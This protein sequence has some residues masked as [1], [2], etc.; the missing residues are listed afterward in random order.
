[1]RNSS[2]WLESYLKYAAVTEAPREMHF[3]TGVSVLA[4][5]LRRKVWLDMKKFVWYPS[6]FIIFVAPPGVVSKSTTVDIGMELLKQVPG[7]NFGPDVVTWQALAQSFAAAGEEFEFEGSF[8]P[9]SP[10][11]L[12]ASELGCLIDPQDR[13]MINFYIE[14][15]D[16]RKG[17]EKVTKGSGSDS[18][19]APWVN[20][21]GCTTPHWIADNMPLAIVG[22]GF[23]SRCIFIYQDTKEQYIPFV[24][25]VA[26]LQ[27]AQLRQE[28]IQ[29]LEHIAASIAGP[30][31]ITAEARNWYRPVYE[32]FWKDTASRVGDTLLEGYAARKQTHLFKLA[33]ILSV[34]QRDDRVI[35]DYDLQLAHT[36]LGSL[37]PTMN[38]VFANIGKSEEAVHMDK[39]IAIIKARGKLPY[40]EA[41]RVVHTHF[42][43][44]K[45]YEDMLSG[46]VR[47]GYLLMLNEGQG[48]MV[49]ANPKLE[50][51]RIA[52]GKGPI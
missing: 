32:A 21:L 14:L 30:F 28:L 11:T 2:N 10:L 22:G 40:E 16:G 34:S 43:G 5:A 15:W 13:Q 42:P 31:T 51:N 48:M 3:W 9:M 4:G 36:M 52:K 25:E 45:N 7:I 18:I 33:M 17:I 29:D 27:D 41:F 38:R 44:A 37:E 49:M 24:D 26:H 12:V 39:L 20:M 1:M 23:T 35:N 19:N 50:S 47:A 6:F 46:A 8:Y